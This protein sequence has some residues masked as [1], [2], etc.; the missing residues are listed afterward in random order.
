VDEG[1]P[2]KIA[3]FAFHHL[4]DGEQ[5]ALKAEYAQPDNLSVLSERLTSVIDALRSNHAADPESAE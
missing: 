2:E 1:K 5:S 3:G 4:D